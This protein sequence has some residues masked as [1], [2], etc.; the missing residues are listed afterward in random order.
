MGHK[1]VDISEGNYGVALLNE[2]KYGHDVKD[3]VLRLSLIKSPVRPD[4]TADQGF[5]EFTYSLL[6]HAGGWREGQVAPEAYALNYPLRSKPISAQHR[7]SLPARFG[8]VRPDAEHV[9]VETIKKAED[10]DAWIVRVYEYQQCRSAEVA[11][12]FGSPITRAV[13]CNLL[14]EEE[15]EVSSE[16]H[17]L[18]FAIAPY[19]IKTFKVWLGV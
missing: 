12:D 19:E 5:H 10:D 9:M 14:E 11:L 8:F 4:P 3:N 6:P 13:E 7:G 18:I 16:G 17:R 2:S 1:W 15:Q